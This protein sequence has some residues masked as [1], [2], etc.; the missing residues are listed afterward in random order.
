MCHACGI[1]AVIPKSMFFPTTHDAVLY[2]N[3]EHTIE[4]DG[5]VIHI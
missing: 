5:E 4:K 1:Y 2:T 3:E